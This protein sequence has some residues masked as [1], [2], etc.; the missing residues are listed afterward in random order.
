MSE[1]QTTGR[2]R[3]VGAEL[4]RIR[5]QTE[6][7]AYKVAAKLGWTPSHISR[8]EAGK[9]RVT[10]VD[11][12]HYLGICDAPDDELQEILKIVREPDDYRLQIHDG[13]IPDQLRTLI[14]FENTATQIRS[15]EPIY[16]PGVAQTAD[17]ARAL[18][19]ETGLAEP[20]QI[21]Y[22]IDVRMAR[23]GFLAKPQPPQCMY[24]VHENA[25]RAP[26]GN[27]RVMNEQ[28]LH[29]LFLG[30][31]THC[32]IRV[33]PAAAGARGMSNGGFEVFGYKDDPPLVFLEHTTTSEFLENDYEVT[34]Y[35]NI[36][37]R[38][39]SVGAPRRR[40]VVSPVQPGRTER[41]FLG[42]MTY[43]ESKGIRGQQHARKSA[44]VFRCGS[45]AL[46]GP[47][48]M[49]KARLPKP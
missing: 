2:R 46:R 11:A 45:N 31:R 36:L 19:E 29:L 48:D 30:D 25:L 34:N 26:V 41:R 7:P 28:I 35:R 3:E 42:L 37:S 22:L 24:F 49:V 5:Q 13:R 27:P 32:A 9:R 14:F 17:Y 10:D 12:G 18:I 8:S 43:P 44:V 15:F 33:I 21:D 39:A 47:R 16:I 4:K 6:Q 23:S 38:V 1:I 20:S 40:S